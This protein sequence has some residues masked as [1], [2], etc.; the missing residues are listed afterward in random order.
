MIVFPELFDP[1]LFSI[2]R[3]AIPVKLAANKDPQVSWL[4]KSEAVGCSEDVSVRDEG[5]PADVLEFPTGLVTN[6]QG[7]GEKYLHLSINL[8][9]L[10]G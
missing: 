7:H 5:A 6:L 1:M 2:A 4:Y 10:K 8:S 3:H 9:L